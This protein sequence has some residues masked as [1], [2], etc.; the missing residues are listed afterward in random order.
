MAAAATVGMVLFLGAAA[1]AA[2]IENADRDEYRITVKEGDET[3]SFSL[4]PGGK[5]VDVCV[6]PCTLQV[7]GVGSMDV[8]EDE[9]VV[10]RNGAL[11]KRVKSI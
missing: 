10:I 2:D 9:F 8:K 3:S 1:S 5:E 7:E 11:S 4:E 6:V